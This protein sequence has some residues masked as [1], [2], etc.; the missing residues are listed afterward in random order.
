MTISQR[1]GDAPGAVRHPKSLTSTPIPTSTTS[2]SLTS[3]W[4]CIWFKNLSLEV[5]T[6]GQSNRGHHH[7][8]P[9]SKADGESLAGEHS[10]Y[11]AKTVPIVVMDEHRRVSQMNS[12]AASLGIAIGHSMDTAY[13]LSDQ[14]I[15]YER[16]PEKEWQTLSYLSQ[17]AYQF[18]PNISLRAPD[19]L[20][21]DIE[22]CLTLFGGLD[23]LKEKIE[24]A[25][26]SMG[27][28]ARLGVNR[29]PQ[30]AICTTLCGLDDNQDATVEQSLHTLPIQHLQTEPEHIQALSRL[31]IVSLG[32][33]IRLPTASLNRRFG[34]YFNDYLCRLLGTRS[35]PLKF[36]SETPHFHSEINFLSDITNL[37]SLASPI[38]RLLYELE[39]FLLGRQ[40]STS[41]ITWRLDHRSHHAKSVNLFLAAPAHDSRMFLTLTQLKLDQI[42][43]VAEVDCLSLTVKNFQPL[44]AR[45]TDLFHGTR[46]AKKQG[47]NLS[48]SN[49]DDQELAL[50]D[51]LNT[52]LGHDACFSLCIADDHRP[53]KAWRQLRLG[54][55]VPKTL[56]PEETAGQNPRPVFLLDT[57]RFLKTD[58]GEPHLGGPLLLLRGPERIDFG[59]WDQQDIEAPL[60]RDYYIARQTTGELIWVFKHLPSDRWFLHGVFA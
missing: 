57:P 58:H 18:T 40:L 15:C 17:W 34:V 9:A 11:A 4:L 7:D 41:H 23:V 43:D 2:I 49:H 56:P 26:R 59:W 6:R 16:K 32:D 47:A 22:G 45:S 53:E 35:D 38:R 46:F 1:S 3:L 14:V 44:E 60:A 36:I 29:T 13:A 42:N 8:V 25:L 37:E 33:L 12:V 19:T 28:V 39:E 10:Q 51:M 20:L 5:F 24:T 21:L 48:D 54:G 50:L 31:G 27:F 30:A 52:R 55:Q